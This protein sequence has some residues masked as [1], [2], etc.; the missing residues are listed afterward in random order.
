M[1]SFILQGKI[2]KQNDNEDQ[3]SYAKVP[4]LPQETKG[5]NFSPVTYYVKLLSLADTVLLAVPKCHR[6]KKSQW[7]HCVSIADF[8][9]VAEVRPNCK[10]TTACCRHFTTV[11]D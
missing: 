9:T 3:S 2:S 6:L 7:S 8:C 5:S 10:F 4:D 11:S 1:F